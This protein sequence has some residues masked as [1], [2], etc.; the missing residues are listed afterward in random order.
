MN[1]DLLYSKIITESR[2]R[3]E[4]ISLRLINDVINEMTKNDLKKLQEARDN[5]Y[6]SYEVKKDKVIAKISAQ[7]ASVFTSLAKSW[8]ELDN[9]VELL[10]QKKRELNELKNKVEAEESELKSKIKEK[11]T[12]VFDESETAMT[13]TVECLNS[14]FTLSKITETNQDKVITPKGGIISTDYKM[15]VD[16]LLEQNAELKETI[17]LLIKKASVIASEDVIKKGAERRVSVAV[18]ENVNEAFTDRISNFFAAVSKK[19][20]HFFGNLNKRQNL[21]NK[22]II[23]LS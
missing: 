20:K 21:I 7:K 5:N 9:S 23:N 4:P 18:G 16:L 19:I 13:L 3:N 17:D 1:T 22:Y 10:A 12:S 8:K 2:Y 6:A 15:V 14:S 11:I